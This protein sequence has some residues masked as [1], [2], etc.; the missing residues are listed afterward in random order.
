[1]VQVAI[2]SLSFIKDEVQ[3]LLR[4]GLISRHQS[5]YTLRWY[6]PNRD[7]DEIELE[8]ERNNFLSRDRIIDLIDN[9]EWRED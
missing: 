6:I 7:W 8:L 9:E 4:Q 1:M 2:Y 5:I 3:E